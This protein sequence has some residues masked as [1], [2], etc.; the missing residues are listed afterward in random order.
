MKEMP[1]TVRRSIELLGICALGVLLV[2]GQSV[3]MPLAMA[4]FI[5]LLLLPLL[6]WFMRRRIPEVISI[7][8]CIA[9]LFVV[10]AGVVA[11][12]SYQIGGFLS[13]FDAIQTNL[14][15]HW[16]NIS[17]W[18]SEKTHFTMRQQLAMIKKQGAGL[19]ENVAGYFQTAMG[20]LSNIFVFLG[21][22]PI[23]IFLILFYR[24]LLVRF[25]YLWFDEPEHP[26]VE[27]AVRETEVIVKYYLFGLLIQISYLT[28]LLGGILL[29]FGIKHAILIGITFA[30]LNLIPYLGA[31]VGNLIGVLLTLTTSQEMW[32]VWAVLGTIAFVQFLDNNILMPR[33]VGSKVKVNALVSIVSIVIGSAVAG[34]SG[35]ILSIPVMAVLKIVFDKSVHLR[36]WGLLLGDDRPNVSPVN[37]RMFRIKRNLEKKHDKEVDEKAEEAGK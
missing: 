27:E 7:V 37:D 4:F 5:S 20:S 2:T 13:D 1:L 8:L 26:K 32:Q 11:F 30:I 24:N 23:Y 9:A 25:V 10:I 12:L 34:V 14:T 18:I 6:R 22:L 29:I 16:N 35:M 3:I 33:I 28:V 17:E 21:L 31:L 15:A 19:G 36:Q